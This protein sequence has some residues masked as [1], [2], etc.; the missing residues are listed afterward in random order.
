MVQ[1][2]NVYI[3]HYNNTRV[4][5]TVRLEWLADGTIKPLFYWTP[6]NSCYE[7]KHIYEKVSLA[8]VKD[9]GEGVRFKVMATALE[10]PEFYSSQYM[11]HEVYLYL[12]NNLFN[13][14][15]IVDERYN[16][17][18]KKFIPVVLD[19]FPDGDYELVYFHVQEAQY[20][21]EKTIAIEPH[22]SYYAGGSGIRHKI[23]ARQI[24]PGNEDITPDVSIKLTRMAALYFELNKWFVI[25]RLRR[26]GY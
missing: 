7:I 25:I 19:V 20:V 8:F 16:H 1:Q 4:P 21:V 3:K 14:R 11:L 2:T 13:G 10:T 17:D 12:A 22:A 18:G 26:A 6:D 9:R 5:V 23:R 24:S 15:N